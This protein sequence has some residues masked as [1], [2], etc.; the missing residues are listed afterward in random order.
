MSDL[1]VVFTG[2]WLIRDFGLSKFGLTG[3][4]LY[5]IEP[6]TRTIRISLSKTTCFEMFAWELVIFC[7]VDVFQVQWVNLGLRWFNVLFSLDAVIVESFAF[8]KNFCCYVSIL[9][10]GQSTSHR[11]PSW[12]F[13]NVAEM[14]SSMRPP[15]LKFMVL[16]PAVGTVSNSW[17]LVSQ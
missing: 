5:L 2:L 15:N 4:Q 7:N 12:E 16:W 10:C 17:D 8:A 13:V 6:L 11:G 3:T 1:G 9:L 14:T